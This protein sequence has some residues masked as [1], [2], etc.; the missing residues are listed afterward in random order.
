MMQRPWVWS[1][2]THVRASWLE[3]FSNA[4]NSDWL[5]TLMVARLADHVC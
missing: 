1:T 3:R 4:L 2:P 5:E